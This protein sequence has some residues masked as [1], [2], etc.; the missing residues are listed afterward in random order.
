MAKDAG[1]EFEPGEVERLG[2][3]LAMMLETN[4]EHNLT[5]ITEPAQAWTRHVFDALTLL[6]VLSELEPGAEVIDVGSGGGVPGV[7]V[8]IAMPQIKFA[9]LEPTGKKAAFLQ[10]VVAELGVTNAKVFQDRAERLGK[11]RTLYRERWDVAI[12]RAVGP[13]SVIAELTLPLVKVGG[14]VLAIKGAKADE[15][16]ASAQYAIVELGGAFER[17]VDTP[18]GRI[19]VLTKV[20]PTPRQYPR[21]DGEPK[22]KPLG[23]GDSTA[24]TPPA[25]TT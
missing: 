15:E 21:H 7:P 18:T 14:F 17:T 19:V 20:R 4:K 25:P 24:N 9:L 12:V 22:R 6:A 8:A 3:F 23:G 16:V 11:D 5:S 1:I 13:L 10:R 2:R